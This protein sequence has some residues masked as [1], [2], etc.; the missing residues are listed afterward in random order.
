MGAYR[1]HWPGDG[2]FGVVMSTSLRVRLKNGHVDQGE[3]QAVPGLLSHSSDLGQFDFN[4][5]KHSIPAFDH[6]PQSDFIALA[7][8]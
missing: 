6:S 4:Q 3:E 8:K 1:A 7:P 5:F 2:Y